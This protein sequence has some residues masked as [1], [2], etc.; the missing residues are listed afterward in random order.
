MLLNN[1]HFH[2]LSLEV[3]SHIW[4]LEININTFT[5]C[6]VC[7]RKM[8]ALL[9]MGHVLPA[10]LVSECMQYTFSSASETPAISNNFLSFGGCLLEYKINIFN[11]L[12][13]QQAL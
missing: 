9:Q 12:S 2:I 7:V 11:Y 10:V 5:M 8:Q 6:G 13:L 1:L 3:A 4:Y